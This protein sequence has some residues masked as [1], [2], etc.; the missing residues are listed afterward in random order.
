MYKCFTF[1]K[2]CTLI[3]V[4]VKRRPQKMHPSTQFAKVPQAFPWNILVSWET[5]K[6][7]LAVTLGDVQRDIGKSF[8]LAITTSRFNLIDYGNATAQSLSHL[9]VVWRPFCVDIVILVVKVIHK[10]ALFQ[11]FC[12][13]LVIPLW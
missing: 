9:N 11:K 12:N 3:Y 13:S 5:S 10:K 8:Q 2:N 4:I 1:I 6:H 7:C